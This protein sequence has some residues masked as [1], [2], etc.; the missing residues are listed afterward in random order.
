MKT[1]TSSNENVI[2]GLTA[3]LVVGFACFFFAFQTKD[4]KVSRSEMQNINYEMAK[5][6]STESLY[7][8]EGREIDRDSQELETT[9]SSNIKT[10]SAKNDKAIAKNKKTADKKTEAQKAK[11]VSASKNDQSIAK[12]S[13][14]LKSK[15]AVEDNKIKLD[16]NDLNSKSNNQATRSVS[17]SETA[18]VTETEKKNETPKNIKTIQQWTKE[19]LAATDRQIILQFAAAYKNKEVTEAEFYSVVNQLLTNSD[20]TKKGFGLYA[21]RA[22]PSYSSYAVLVKT[23][24]TQNAS[25]QAYIQETLLTYNQTANLNYLRTALSSTDKQLI[26]K[27]L[28]IIKTGIT[29]I[30]NG[31]TSSLIES[32]YRRDVAT[33]AFQAQSY[34][35]FLPL[36]TLLQNQSQQSGD[37]DIFAAAQLLS[38]TIQSTAVVAAN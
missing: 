3:F 35:A 7:S 25:Y 4:Q 26:L 2:L 29:D 18:A 15:Y 32:R 20:E 33:T 38:Q 30:K 27:T 22:T 34:Q 11:A 37:Q 14:T 36:L 9:D 6:K 17:N 24:S 10:A 31:T 1:T 19:I 8:L 21:L 23:Q 13:D 5:A 28:D 12:K 16:T